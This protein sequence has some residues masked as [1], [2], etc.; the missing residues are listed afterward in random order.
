MFILPPKKKGLELSNS[1]YIF[2]GKCRGVLLVGQVAGRR[3][4]TLL[5]NMILIKIH[6]NV[7]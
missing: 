4:A 6:V 2:H 3:S 7:A 5:K 1:G